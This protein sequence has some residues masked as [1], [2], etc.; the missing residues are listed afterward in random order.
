M[1]PFATTCAIAAACCVATTA[2]A[3]AG[4]LDPAF[5][6]NGVAVLRLP[7][8]LRVVQG[9]CALA[10]DGE[11]DAV[12]PLLLPREVLNLQGVMRVNLGSRLQYLRAI[13]GLL[14]DHEAR[15]PLRQNRLCRRLKVRPGNRVRLRG[16]FPKAPA[17]ISDSAQHSSH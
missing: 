9:H 5:G 16:R 4:A 6:R 15:R 8:L 12:A 11:G 17:R 10:I 7:D 2:G 13:L 1:H 14:V 3:A